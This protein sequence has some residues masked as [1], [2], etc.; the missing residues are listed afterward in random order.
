MNAKPTDEELTNPYRPNPEE[1]PALRLSAVAFVDL[2][3]YSERIRTAKSIEE[4]NAEL[5]TISTALQKASQWIDGKTAFGPP[6]HVTRFFTDCL[7]VGHPVYD[8]SAE[9]EPEMGYLFFFLAMFQF[10]MARHG[11]FV[12]GALSV[13]HLYVDKQLVFGD[14]LLEA[15]NAEKDKARDPRIVLCSSAMQRVEKQLK[16]YGNKAWAPHNFDLLRD[17]DGQVFIDYLRQTILMAEDEAG[18]FFDELIEH[19][20]QVVQNLE[21]YR[22]EPR[23]WSKYAWVGRYH[24]WFCD[25][26]PKYFDEGHKV[27]AELLSTTPDLLIPVG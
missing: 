25:Q 15:T 6:T 7:V 17:T 18:P 21:Q 12:R 5:S 26:Y 23:V 24:N 2:L 14:A 10:E 13:G 19:R 9:A 27:P 3:G 11:V 16:W 8:P 20:D 22:V 1:P 4:A